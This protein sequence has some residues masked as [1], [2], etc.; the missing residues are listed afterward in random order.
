[1]ARL[2]VFGREVNEGASG[3]I[4]DNVREARATDAERD[5]HRRV[6]CVFLSDAKDL[7]EIIG[8]GNDHHVIG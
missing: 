1:V 2:D 8:R 6:G 4:A 3:R 5:D 7:P